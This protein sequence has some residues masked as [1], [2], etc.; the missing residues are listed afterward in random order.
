MLTGEQHMPRA[1]YTGFKCFRR[2][3][4]GTEGKHKLHLGPWKGHIVQLELFLLVLW[5][6]W[7]GVPEPW[8]APSSPSPGQ[9]TSALPAAAPGVLESQP[10]LACRGC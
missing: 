8:A 1:A 9:R 6:G 10:G 2:G 5:L 3:F 4:C 7:A